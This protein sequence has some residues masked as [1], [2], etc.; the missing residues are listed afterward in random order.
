MSKPHRAATIAAV[1]LLLL[2][3]SMSPAQA[4]TFKTVTK[5][6]NCDTT[7]AAIGVKATFSNP[8]TVYGTGRYMVT[9]EIRWDYLKA[10]GQWR[11]ADSVKTQTNWLKI[12]NPDYDFVSSIG[13]KTT[14]GLLYNERW[15]AHITIKLIKNR[16]GPRDR[17]VDMIEIWPAKGSFQERGS[18][19]CGGIIV[20]PS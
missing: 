17:R 14:W 3:A 18:T 9:K 13:D 15:R 20:G 1:I 11:R 5:W 19:F 7:K 10:P 8:A 4:G 2:A 16:P 12:S 6:K